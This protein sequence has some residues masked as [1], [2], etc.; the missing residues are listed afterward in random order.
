MY[1]NMMSDAIEQSGPVGVKLYPSQ[2]FEVGDP[3][4]MAVCQYCLEQDVPIQLVVSSS[5]A[6]TTQVMSSR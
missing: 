4:M 3:A 6:S 1:I 5:T 2:G